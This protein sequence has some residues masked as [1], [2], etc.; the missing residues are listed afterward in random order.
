MDAL[1]RV[2]T[3]VRLESVVRTK[4]GRQIYAGARDRRSGAFYCVRVAIVATASE[5]LIYS[6][7]VMP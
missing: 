1:V 2:L 3:E 4:A 7:H 6:D 5:F